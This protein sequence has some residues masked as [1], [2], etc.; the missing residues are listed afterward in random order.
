MLVSS[1]N[2]IGLDIS[3]IIFGRL[4]MYKNKIMVQVLS[5]VEPCVWSAPIYKNISLNNFLTKLSDNVEYVLEVDYVLGKGKN[6]FLYFGS[7][8]LG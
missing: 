2:Q 7:G 6:M 3:D 1:A 5:L 8:L 4:L